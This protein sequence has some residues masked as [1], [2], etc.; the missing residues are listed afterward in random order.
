MDVRLTVNEDNCSGCR[1]CELACAL[2]NSRENNP[3][4]ARLRIRGTFPAPGKYSITYCDQC[5]DCAEVC[6]VEAIRKQED[7]HYQLFEDECIGCLTCVETCPRDAI[8]THVSREIPL[9]C[10]N[11]GLC[12]DYCPR[13][14]IYDA[15][16][17]D[18]TKFKEFEEVK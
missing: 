17:P 4:L 12:V 13:N 10:T 9:K 2:E 1:T 15:D 16:D 5:G 14:A 7:G 3:R 18:K 8:F 11:C 6:P